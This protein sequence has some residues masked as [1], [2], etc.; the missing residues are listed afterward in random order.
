MVKL[1][2]LTSL[3]VSNNYQVNNFLLESAINLENDRN[4]TIYC[5]DTDVNTIEFE[6][7]Y[8]E[9]IRKNLD[10]NYYSFKFK[11]LTFECGLTLRVSDINKSNKIWKQDG[12]YYIGSPVESDDDEYENFD[13]EGYNFDEIENDENFFDDDEETEMYNELD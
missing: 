12:F 10:F 1:I 4:I 8:P 5:N 3:D 13:D 7:K 9:T 11:K 2:N 6:Y